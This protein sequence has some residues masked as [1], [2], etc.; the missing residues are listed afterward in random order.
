MIWITQ[1][2]KRN[3]L[4]LCFHLQSYTIS[5]RHSQGTHKKVVQDTKYQIITLGPIQR[6]CI[7]LRT[8]RSF[9]LLNYEFSEFYIYL[10]FEMRQM[11][12]IK[13]YF[14]SSTRHRLFNT[15]K[16]YWMHVLYNKKI[17]L[18]DSDK[19]DCWV[20]KP[21]WDKILNTKKIQ[22][23]IS[24]SIFTIFIIKVFFQVLLRS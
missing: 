22:K 6:I 18:D 5:K 12:K 11:I 8:P 23:A 14:Q 1:L 10:H 21:I 19:R 20:L 13:Y 9:N 16:Y 3:D 7:I 4:G 15:I 24:K 2:Q 17:K